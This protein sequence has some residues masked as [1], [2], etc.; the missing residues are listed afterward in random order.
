VI[1]DVMYKRS[2][3]NIITIHNKQYTYTY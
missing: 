3:T 2:L 1:F